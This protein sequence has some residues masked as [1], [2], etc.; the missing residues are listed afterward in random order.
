MESLL[1]KFAFMSLDT[2]L[3]AKKDR[4]KAPPEKR[5]KVAF[6]HHVK[7]AQNIS[8]ITREESV[9]H[10]SKRVKTIISGS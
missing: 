2:G 9:N 4:A 8:L 5:A 1:S 7:H 3:C 6:V 10:Q